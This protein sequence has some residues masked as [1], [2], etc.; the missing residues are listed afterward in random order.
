M[1]TVTGGLYAAYA[2]GNDT[3]LRLNAGGTLRCN[4]FDYTRSGSTTRFYGN[5]GE[6]HPLGLTE[7]TCVM[8]NT[9]AV[10]YAVL[11]PTGTTLI[12]R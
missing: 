3:T 2:S 12:F 11:A 10:V 6:F 9:A 4:R 1:Y 7:A 8:T 5:G